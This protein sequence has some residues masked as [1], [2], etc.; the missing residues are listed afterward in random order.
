MTFAVLELPD[1][2]QVFGVLHQGTSRCVGL[3]V[4]GAVPTHP[5]ADHEVKTRC[6]IQIIVQGSPLRTV[7][8]PRCGA[9]WPAKGE[10]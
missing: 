10:R 8:G 4:G 9:C 7:Y 3:E 5:P 6:G 2:I 1:G